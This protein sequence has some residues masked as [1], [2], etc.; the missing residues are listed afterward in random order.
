MLLPSVISVMP[1]STIVVFHEVVN[2]KN[3]LFLSCILSSST[4][5]P[6]LS[7]DV[8]SVLVRL[9]TDAFVSTCALSSR[10]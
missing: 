9:R 1:L 3:I 2:G 5:C 4:A 7:M 6:V 10:E 8:L